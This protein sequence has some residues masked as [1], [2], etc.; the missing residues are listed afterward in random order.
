MG[1]LSADRNTPRRRGDDFSFPVAAAVKCYAGAIAVLDS[2]GDVK[3]GVT[4]TGLICVGRFEAQADNSAGSAGDIRAQVSRGVFQFANSAAA[5]AISADEVGD[6]CYIVDDQTVA[7]TSATGTRSVA[8]LIVDVDAD[9][10][11]VEMGYQVYVS[12]AGSLLAANNLSDLGTAATARTNL[13]GGADKVCLPMGPVSLVGGDAAV[14][15]M[16]A[17]VAGDIKA[18]RTVLN[19]ALTTGDA[20]LTGKINGDAITTGVV[21]ITQAGSAAGDVDSAVPTAANTVAV[22]DVISLTVGGTNDATVTADVVIEITPS[23]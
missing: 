8:G 18:I 16:V 2:S 13:G 4:A 3:P 22:G 14:L 20:T 12:P 17:P 6:V 7:K 19:G 5:D 10:V 23:A 15:R 21:T 11:W 1:A 9:G